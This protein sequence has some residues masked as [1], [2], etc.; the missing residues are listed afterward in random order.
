VGHLL[1]AREAEWP[2]NPK[3]FVLQY[4]R[5]I[6]A[7]LDRVRDD[8]AGLIERLGSLEGQVVGLRRDFSNLRE[9]FVRLE[10]RMDQFD[11]RVARIERRLDLVEA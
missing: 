2:R 10:H 7:K 5:R 11:V 1:T 9:D 3:I 6:D 8:L 4:L